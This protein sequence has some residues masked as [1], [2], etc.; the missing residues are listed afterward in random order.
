MQSA[1]AIDLSGITHITQ[2]SRDVRPGTLFVAL[3]GEK[4][5]GAQ[6]IPQAETAGAV[7]VLC[8]DDAVIPAT[9][10]QVIRVDEPRRTLAELAARFYPEQP[11][12]MVAVTGTDG[13]TS[14]ADFYRQLVQLAGGKSASIG[15]LGVI[16]GNGERLRE[17]TLTTPG[18]L[19]L[20]QIFADLAKAAITHA[21]MEASSHGLDQYRLHGT[22]LEAAAFTNIA[23]DH[24]DYHKN[25]EEYWH[26]KQRLFS[27]ILPA[28]GIAVIN[29]DDARSA[30]LKRICETHR[31]RI[32]DFGYH[33]DSFRIASLVPHANGQEL[34]CLFNGHEERLHIPL[35]G[36]FQAMNILAAIGLA[37]ASG[38]ALKPLLQAVP[39]L[40][41]VPGRL[42]HAATC[43]NGAAIY[44]DYAHTPAALANILKTLR[45]HT[46]GRLHVV[47]GCGGNRDAGKRPEM[48][49]IACELADSVIVTDDNPRGENPAAIRAA[50]MAACPR[51]TEVADRAKAIHAAER[52]LAAGD[53][54]IIA[55]K[56]H[57]KI[58]VIGNVEHPHD[59]VE[60][61]REA[62][63]R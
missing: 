59:D 2:D 60:V 27:E 62:V 13:K 56:G 37:T 3:K 11:A 51:A 33:A 48:G 14:T 39:Q 20:H 15:T 21:C 34:H 55:G 18:T 38:I 12:H 5:D 29:A 28:G 57:E 16:G 47:F 10:M 9:R 19:A 41:G 7:A 40:Q 36:S 45:A 31:H 63:K 58:Q 43:K 4:I 49:K 32:L 54:L 1:P 26:A 61:A 23:R 17:G 42:E 44:V 22:R 6:F 50:I 52:G 30:E 24:L 46:A 8:A 53:I 25:E 35:V